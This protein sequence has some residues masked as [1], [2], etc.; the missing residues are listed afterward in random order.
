MPKKLFAVTNVKFSGDGADFVAAGN[1]VDP[2]KFSKEDLVALHDAG[3]IEV[4]I[5]E[6]EEKVAERPSPLDDPDAVVV[7]EVAEAKAKEAADKKAADEKAAAEKKAAED[8]V[9]AAT[10]AKTTPTSTPAKSEGTK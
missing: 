5:V 6:A 3:A 1:E 2:S 8:V 7:D 10:P 4:R 9:K